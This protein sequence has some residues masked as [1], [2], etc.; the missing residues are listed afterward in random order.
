MECKQIFKRYEIK[1]LISD[2]QKQEILNRMEGRMHGDEWGRSTICNLYLDTPY[3]LLIR[4]SLEKPVYK[5]KLRLRSYGTASDSSTV[6]LE[7]KKKYRSVVYKRRAAM[8]ESEA[9]TC[10]KCG[11]TDGGTQ[12][13][14]EINYAFEFYGALEPRVFISYEREAFFA[15]GDEDFR[16]TFDSHI[17]WRDYDLSLQKGAYG[18]KLLPEGQTLMEIKTGGAIPLWFVKE[19]SRIGLQ[20]TSFS[21]YGNA[22]TQLYYRRKEEEKNDA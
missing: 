6:F 2:A 22:Y 19:L 15:D 7:L 12:I 4:R 1:Y 3:F 14:R 21:K 9:Q 20:K 13:L 10:L 8:K 17:L 16:V 11:R 5:E 18:E